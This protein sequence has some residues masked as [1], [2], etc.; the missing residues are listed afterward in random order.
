MQIDGGC[1]CGAVTY[2][3]DVNPK[4]V[5]ICHCT[6]C[7]MLSGT[8]FRTVLPVRSENFELLSGELSTYVKTAE[9]GTERAMKFCPI[10]ATQIYGTYVGD[11]PA[12]VSLRVGTVRQ[13]AELIPQHQIWCRSQVGW[14]SELETM[15]ASERELEAR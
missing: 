13:R 7:Q 8:A 9:S 1:H 15:P 5:V 6:D 10:C 2:R 12:V 11:E 4:R 14:L 3:A